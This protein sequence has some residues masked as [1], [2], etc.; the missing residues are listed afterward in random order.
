MSI[1]PGRSEQLL[2]K[3]KGIHKVKRRQADGSFKIH[4]YAW[5][6]GPKMQSQPHTEA[7]SRE[8][9]RL[10]EKAEQ[11]VKKIDT[12][13]T[14]IE[15]FTGPEHE[16]NPAFTMLADTTQKDY[17]YAFKLIKKEW[18]QLPARLTQQ[19][20]FKGDIIKWH[21]KFAAN[22][23]KADKLLIALSKIFTYALKTEHKD[24]DKNPCSGIDQLYHGTRKE[25]VW[26][27]DQIKLF[28]DRAPAHLLLPFEIAIYT[29]Q[30]QGDIL[31]ASWKQYDGIYLKFRQSKGDKQ[32]KVK[33]HSKLKARLDAVVSKDTLRICMNSRGRP[34]TKHGFQASWQKELCRLKIEDVTFH[35][36]RGTF[37]TERRREGSSIE[38]IALISGHAVK[39]IKSILEKH[40]LAD[41]QGL[42]D[43]VIER[44]EQNSPG[45]KTVNHL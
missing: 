4:N 2:I 22:P 3:I 38:N 10:K 34:W 23:R 31:A 39:E 36:L 28:R 37:I 18:P 8:H 7:F 13:E 21:S 35:D 20:G 17:L 27:V 32:L 29:S 14:L 45:T 41:D 9:A 19:K 43:G 16:R 11:Q 5:R 6:G 40:Y 44:M 1:E 24:I 25:N 42:S 15:L 30:R 12:L 26:S 33:V